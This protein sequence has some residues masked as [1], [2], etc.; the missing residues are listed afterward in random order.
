MQ[1]PL[2][3]KA[4]VDRSQSA[5]KRHFDL[6]ARIYG[7]VVAVNLVDKRKDQQ[8]LGDGFGSLVDWYETQKR[9]EGLQ[10]DAPAAA[11]K[12]VWFDFHA[13]CSKMRWHRLSRLLDLVDA[14]LTKHG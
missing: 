6:L 9:S 5:F 7:D 13:E 14:D 8:L 3:G 12:Y 4:W 1:G 11:L 2:G 10:H